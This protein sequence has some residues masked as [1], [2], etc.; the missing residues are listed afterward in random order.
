MKGRV[1]MQVQKRTSHSS[2]LWAGCLI[3][4]PSP[5]QLHKHPQFQLSNL[6]LNSYSNS[7]IVTRLCSSSHINLD[8][9]ESA[10]PFSLSKNFDSAR[11]APMPATLIADYPSHS[12]ATGPIASTRA[13][14]TAL[15]DA[16]SSA[17]ERAFM[18]CLKARAGAK[19]K[20]LHV[21]RL[22]VFETGAKINFF[23]TKNP[24]FSSHSHLRFAAHS[25]LRPPAAQ[26]LRSLSRRGGAWRPAKRH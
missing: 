19:G 13:V 9:A 5:I 7:I 24:L 17:D 12:T 18:A 15:I 11:F 22:P 26:S 4:S 6:I 1:Q 8:S 14:A 16:S 21:R 25:D 2:L 23:R 10:K 20:P 3:T